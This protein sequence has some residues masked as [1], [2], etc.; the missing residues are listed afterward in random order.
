[1]Y[2]GIDIGSTTIKTV[3]CD[4]D[5]DILYSDYRRH[6]TDITA[7]AAAMLADMAEKYP[8]AQ[9][10][11]GF[12][13]SVGMGYAETLGGT[14]VQEVICAAEVIRERYPDVK[15]LIDIGGEDSKMIF[16]E[17][18]R[19]PDIR[20]NGNCAG[21]TGAFIDQ[22]GGQCRATNYFALI[23][24]A[25][26]AEGFSDIPLISISKKPELTANQP[27]FDPD[28]KHNLRLILYTV[29]YADC[30]SKLYHTAVTREKQK[31]RAA[32]L[33]HKYTELGKALILRRD[34]RG[35]KE[36]IGQAAGEFAAAIRTELHPRIIGIVGEI[37]VKYNSFSNKDV[38]R[39]LN[40]HGIETA[41]P[42]VY[43][44]FISAFANRHINK[45]EHIKKLQTP[46]W[47]TDA[48]YLWMRRCARA[49]DR[50]CSPCPGYRPFSDVF[51]DAAKASR[52]V[53]L[54]GDFGE[55]WSLPAEIAGLAEEGIQKVVSLQPFGCIANHIISK[56]VEKRIKELYPGLSLLFLDFDSNTSE[57]NIY[58]RLQFMIQNDGQ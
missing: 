33:R 29:L 31:G 35:L 50:A 42:S 13:G 6:N 28:W 10:Q 46:L 43:N 23:Q 22:T 21:G 14:F 51:E 25:M 58:N 7:T 38:V 30:L 36:L 39:W 45:R 3:L 5:G 34:C 47:A 8:D 20:M 26:C 17:P 48:L 41:V 37:Y 49:F 18:G 57:A 56:G 53:S 44:F 12:T 24:N 19:V 27:G 15:T 16:F 9:V 40:S 54:A 2:L 55:G 52:I 11:A 32:S 1:M 4:R